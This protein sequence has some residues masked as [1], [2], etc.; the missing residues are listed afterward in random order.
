MS[1]LTE[2]IGAPR[3][4]TITSPFCSPAFAERLGPAPTPADLCRQPLVSIYTETRAWET[5]FASAGVQFDACTPYLV[6][7][8]LAVALEM[9]LSGKGIALVN[10]PFVEQDLASQRLVQPVD[11]KAICPGE[12]GLICRKEMKDNVRVRTFIDWMVRHAGSAI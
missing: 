3:H 4:D 2:S 5:W 7:D 6:V 8:T 12:W 10:G 11:H 9:A 1:R